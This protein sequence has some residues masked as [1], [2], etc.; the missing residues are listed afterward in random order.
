M[1]YIQ[2]NQR[3]EV[4]VND[5]FDLDQFFAFCIENL[6]DKFVESIGMQNIRSI[7]EQVYAHTETLCDKLIE[8]SDGEF[9]IS[10]GKKYLKIISVK[11]D[12]QQSAH[13]FVDKNT[14]EVYKSSSWKS[15]AKSVRFNL[16]D[17]ES[18]NLCYSNC[19]AYGC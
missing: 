7:Q 12:N 10:R 14:G 3:F 16:M 11:C 4:T 13:A 18:R 6:Y 19:D 5:H 8:K 17:D 9:I 1:S 2:S 15:P